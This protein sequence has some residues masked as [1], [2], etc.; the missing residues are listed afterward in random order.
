[1]DTS[2][3][4]RKVLL[5]KAQKSSSLYLI[6]VITAI[7]LWSTS[8]VGTKIAF[9]SFPPLTLGAAR[10]LIASVILGAIM[11]SRKEF[12]RPAPKDMG[13][14]ALSGILGTTLYFALENIELELT[15]AS[16]AALIVASYPAIT[17]LLE[18]IFYRVKISWL[19]GL[20]IV[21]AVLGVYQISGG[22]SEESSG[23]LTGNIILILA[24]VVF[25]AYNFT[26]RKVV[27]NYSMV[28][29]SFYQTIAGTL[30]FIPLALIERSR[31]QVPSVESL[32]MLLYLGVF[33]SIAAF[34]LYN[35]G[36]RNLSSGTAM[37]LMNLVPLFGVLFSSVFL[38][39]VLHIFD[40]IGGMIIIV[41]VILSVREK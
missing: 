38:H 15:T 32:W 37:A 30:A 19:K 7:L 33:C 11:L 23:Q 14:M 8:F 2:H 13:L 36:L 12:I 18:F 26:T 35:Y 31:W 9:N 6:A 29:V 22:S 25:A 16:S 34:M 17:A 5:A 27:K 28:T 10:F 39:E 40:L 24:G 1:M 41:G 21:M 20:G 4:I 3:E